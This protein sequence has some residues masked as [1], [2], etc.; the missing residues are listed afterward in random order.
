MRKIIYAQMVSLDGFVEGPN[1]EL[2]W[3]EPGPELHKHFNDQYLTGEIDTSLYGRRLYE[4]MASYW[5]TVNEDSDVPEVEKEFARLWVNIPKT[6][7]SRTLEE[8]NWN[9]RLAREVVPDEI[10]QLKQQPGNHIEVGG[11]ELAGVFM[12]H[13]LV[14]EFW[15]YIHPV[16]LGAGKPVFPAGLGIKLTLVDTLTF[17]CK[18][19]RLR[20]ERA[21]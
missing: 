4:I 11:A 12:K 15:L 9:S 14:D 5:P 7:F 21:D 8:V 16:I 10:R 20:Y 6:V 19:V 17:P 18:V 3:S 13:G 1:G 2:S